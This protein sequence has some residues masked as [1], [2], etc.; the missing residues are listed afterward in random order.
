MALTVPPESNVAKYSGQPTLEGLQARIAQ[1]ERN[2]GVVYNFYQ[3]VIARRDV[4]AINSYVN[5]YIQHDPRAADGVEG[6]DE[7]LKGLK[8]NS[9]AQIKRLVAEGDYVIAHL[10]ISESPDG[11]FIAAIDM[12]R[13]EGDKIVEHW[14][15]IQHVPESSRNNNS[16]F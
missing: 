14:D 9:S 6:L 7:F 12:F 2:K 4:A 5:G 11:P 15:V 3:N 13:F 10:R 1:Q 16:M 8:P